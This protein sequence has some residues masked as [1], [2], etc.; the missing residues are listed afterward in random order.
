MPKINSFIIL[1][2]FTPS[3]PHSLTH[4]LIR[5]IRDRQPLPS[6]QELR[7][8]RDGSMGKAET[9]HTSHTTSPCS[10]GTVTTLCH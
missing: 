3:L 10:R 2:S 1:T 9:S 6:L 5:W 4:S 8:H 7:T